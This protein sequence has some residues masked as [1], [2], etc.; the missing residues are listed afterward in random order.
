MPGPVFVALPTVHDPLAVICGVAAL[1]V[2][3]FDMAVT[4]NV[5]PL[6]AVAGAPVKLTVGVAFFAGTCR[7]ALAGE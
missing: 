3:S 4:V 5:A 7:Y 6:L 1:P 2:V